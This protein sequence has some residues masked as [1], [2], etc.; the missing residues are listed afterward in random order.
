MQLKLERLERQRALERERARIARD[1][2]DDLGAALTQIGMLSQ[3]AL[4]QLDQ[5]ASI[6]PGLRQIF[7]A[8]RALTRA[9]DEIVW[10]VNPRHDS[11]DS[12]AT[13]LARFAQEFLRPTGLR[14]RLDLP[15]ELPHWLLTAEIRHNLFLACKEALNN[16]VKHASARQVRLA[17]TLDSHGFRLEIADDGQGFDPSQCH[18][19]AA[20]LPEADQANGLENMRRRLQEIGGICEIQS[21]PGRGTRVIFTVNLPAGHRIAA[22]HHQNS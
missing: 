2:H 10:A 1:L 9:L 13:Y 12:L 6:A 14:C 16:V 7:D 20:S 21:E 4:Q 8:A 11:L 17:L 22:S 18:S 3:N 5:P 15:L 19:P